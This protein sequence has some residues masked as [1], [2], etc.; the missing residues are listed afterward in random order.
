MGEM[1]MV[2]L[3]KRI[4]EAAIEALLI[5]WAF[6]WCVLIVLLPAAGVIWLIKFF[7]GLL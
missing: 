3:V 7:G 1:G 2:R 6:L 4:G 5:G